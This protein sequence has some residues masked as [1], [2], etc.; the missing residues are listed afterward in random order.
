MNT[1]S[2][3]E[4]AP[5]IDSTTRKTV[6]IMQPYFLPYIGYFQLIAASDAFVLHDDV[7]YIK[8]GW[9]NRNRIL[10]GGKDRMITLPV[11]YGPH[12]SPINRREYVDDRKSRVGLLNL[13]KE[14]YAKAPQF[15]RVFP[16]AEAM[17]ADPDANVARFNGRSIR[18][19]CAYMGIRTPIVE[20]SSIAKNDALAGEARVIEICRQM[21]ATRYVNPIGGTGLY[22]SGAFAQHAIELCFLSTSDTPYRQM[23]SGWVPSLSILDVLMFN[24]LDALPSLLASYRLHPAAQQSNVEPA[25]T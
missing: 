4:R 2:M 13:I 5:R 23:G 18:A 19:I 3:P 1:A 9:V 6:A 12:D 17:L 8:G 10:L 21:G 14:G 24:P 25:R 22:R 11:R 7:Q 15:P 16:M 20:S